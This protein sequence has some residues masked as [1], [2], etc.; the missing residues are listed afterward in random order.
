M[1]RRS[2]RVSGNQIEEAIK[3][4]RV[5]HSPLFLVRYLSKEGT[6][7]SRVAAVV[8]VKVAKTSALRH[9]VRRRIYEAVRPLM[10]KISTGHVIILFAKSTVLKMKPAEIQPDIK[11][12]FVKA[13]FLR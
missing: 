2:Q 8:P 6:S 7:S 9:L 10:S 13:G 4:G 3:R 11:S 5:L 1:I 12:I